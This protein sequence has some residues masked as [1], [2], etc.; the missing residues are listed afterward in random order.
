MLFGKVCNTQNLGVFSKNILAINHQEVTQVFENGIF[1]HKYS[2]FFKKKFRLKW[3]E[4]WGF[5]WDGVAT[6][7]STGYSF[8]SSLQ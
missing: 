5:F 1:C 2:L 4:N 7:M 8:R 6:F 3:P